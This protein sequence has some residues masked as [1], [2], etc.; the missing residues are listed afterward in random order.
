MNSTSRFAEKAD[1]ARIRTLR[2]T[3]F[4]RR[5]RSF[6]RCRI[7]PRAKPIRSR[8]VVVTI[9]TITGGYRNNIIADEVQ[10][11]GTLRAHDPQ[12]R[13]GL[14]ARVRRIV[15]HAAAAY[16]ATA[17]IRIVRGYPPVVNDVAL[18]EDFARY[19]REHSTLRVERF[20]A[21]DGCRG[22][23]VFRASAYPAVHVR[24][25]IRSEAA[26]SVH[27][28]HSPEFRIDEAALALRGADAGRFCDR[29]R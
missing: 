23:R 12:I 21:D 5:A 24:L 1:T 20:R 15:E 9:G 6:S 3:R 25:G 19:M 2:S 28:G 29:G 13:N 18:A 10:M 8:V 17:E 11:A 22:F 7:S 4:R 26:G 16:G 27:P 14:E